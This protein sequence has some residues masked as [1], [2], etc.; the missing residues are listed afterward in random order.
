MNILGILFF[1]A[2]LFSYEVSNLI[3]DKFPGSVWSVSISDSKGVRILDL[4]S[5]SL[6]VPASSIKVITALYSLEKLGEDYRFK[7]EI[8]YS[9]KI[10]K[11]VLKGD[12]YVKGYGDM[13]LGSE[14]FNSDIDSV[15][16]EIFESV[17]K[18]GIKKIDGKIYADSSILDDFQEGSWEWQDI[19]NYYASRVTALSINDNSYKIYFQTG[20]QIGD[21]TKIVKIEPD[22]DIKFVNEVLTGEDKTGDNSYIY[23]NP[24]MDTAIIKGSIGR[25]EGL[26]AVKGSIPDPPLYFAKMFY[27]FLYKNGIKAEGYGVLKD[28]KEDLKLIKTLYSPPVSEIIKITNKKS[29]NFYAESLLRYSGIKENEIGLLKNL[30]SLGSYLNSVGVNNFKIVDGSG[31]SRRN[32]LSC[33]GFIK[34][35]NEAKKKSYFKTF[36]DSL[37]SPGDSTAKGHIKNF[38]LRKKINTRVKSGSLNGIRSYVGYLEDKKGEIYSFCFIANNYTSSPKEIDDFWEDLLFDLIENQKMI[39]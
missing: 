22:M 26:F 37:I 36:Y 23:S 30:K 25:T 13:T 38:G 1:S 27:G 35:L 17:K 14:N 2:K 8:L 3:N 12:L 16:S 24:Y 19:G 11:G 20:K 9:G 21:K 6:L 15:L 33:D 39:K 28:K 10:D 5:S 7:T 18:I 32:L 29:F 4:N 31:L 34:V